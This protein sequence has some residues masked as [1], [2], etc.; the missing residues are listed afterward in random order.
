VLGAAGGG[1]GGGA[2][3]LASSGT[4]D[5]T[6]SILANGGAGGDVAGQDSGG[7]GGAGSGGA[8][9]IIATSISG[10]GTIDARGGGDQGND[11]FSVGSGR[12]SDGRIKLEAE[13]ITRTSATT[14]GF[15]FTGPQDV[16]L[17]NIPGVRIAS[18]AGIAA[19]ASPTGAGDIVVPEA[20]PNPVAI[21]FATTNI[22]VGNTIE[23][24]VS[25][26]SGANTTA[27]SGAIT[28]SDASGTASVSVEI[29]N[30]PSTLSASVT[31]TIA[32]AS[33]QEDYSMFAKGNKVEKIRIDF[34][35]Q[36]GSMTTFIA[37]NGNEYTWPSNTVAIN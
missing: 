8:I 14:P 35:P 10:N 19:P 15:V 29:P 18:V 28:G 11:Q 12:G 6:G 26:Q 7:A 21:E 27:V 3:L 23:L 2:I 1:G 4:V 22:P 36:Q 34:D 9:R 5:V 30:G 24:T 16:F 17:A 13:N 20:T 37:S 32:V 31:F 33:L 25:P